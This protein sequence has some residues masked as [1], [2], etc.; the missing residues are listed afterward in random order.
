MSPTGSPARRWEHKRNDPQG[1]LDIVG[2]VVDRSAAAAGAHVGASGRAGNPE[3]T[4]RVSSRSIRKD[5]PKGPWVRLTIAHSEL[6][7]DSED[8]A[9]R[10]LRLAGFDVGAED[11]ARIGA[12]K[13]E[14]DAIG[15]VEDRG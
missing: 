11:A 2:A 14:L 1:T 10:Q 9:Q 5:W 15:E 3:E 13:R 8:V 6:E 4:S 12:L 7:P